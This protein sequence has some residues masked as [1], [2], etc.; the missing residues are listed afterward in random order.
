MTAG[1]SDAVDKIPEQE[2]AELV[3]QLKRRKGEQAEVKSTG[4]KWF[5]LSATDSGTDLIWV[6]EEAPN[7]EQELQKFRS[8]A[9]KKNVDRP[10]LASTGQINGKIRRAAESVDVDLLTREDIVDGIKSED[11]AE[12][13]TSRFFDESGDNTHVEDPNPSSSGS[14]PTSTQK[15]DRSISDIA[16]EASGNV[17]EKHLSDTETSRPIL[18]YLHPEEQLQYLF[19]HWRKGVRIEG[20]NGD[21]DTPYNTGIF[22]AKR[23][24]LLITD[25]RVLFIAGDPDSNDES[26][27]IPHSKIKRVE[28]ELKIMKQFLKIETHDGRV[29]TFFDGGHEAEHLP[30]A[31]EYLSKELNQAGGGPVGTQENVEREDSNNHTSEI[32]PLESSDK[33]KK[34]ITVGLILS[35]IVGA[36]TFLGVFFVDYSVPAYIP[37]FLSGVIVFPPTRRWLEDS[38][39]IKMSRWLVVVTFVLLQ[40]IGGALMGP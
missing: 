1:L 17:K 27:D 20:P 40:I 16:L 30:D 15:E 2:L 39:N 31:K 10:V 14:P 18:S 5:V 11:L 35:Y 24:Y 8:F 37:L 34:D 19:Y 22:S 9:E 29:I 7:H 33:S 4:E 32:D 38:F 25:K 6:L 28:S 36:V 3:A 26:L 21:V 12:S 23:R 13:V